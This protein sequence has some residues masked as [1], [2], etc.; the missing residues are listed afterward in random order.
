MAVDAMPEG[1]RLKNVVIERDPD[2]G[3]TKMTFNAEARNGY[4]V[5][6]IS[7]STQ[8]PVGS[9]VVGEGSINAVIADLADAYTALYPPAP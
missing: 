4:D 2:T 3:Y 7:A 9:T 1:V 8:G 6:P 5:N